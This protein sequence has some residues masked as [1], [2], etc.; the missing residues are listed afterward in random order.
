M[1]LFGGL[2]SVVAGVST[3]GGNIITS[4]IEK[5]TGKKLGRTTKE[6]F[7]ESKTG[8]VL[9]TGGALAITGL[10]GA[11]AKALV[12]SAGG[13]RAVT[14]KIV[15]NPIGA[16]KTT[17]GLATTSG[18]VAGGGL[19]LLPKVFDI[20]KSAT[21]TLTGEKPLTSESSG[22]VGKV[23]GGVLAGTVVGA[24]AGA[25]LPKVVDA[26]KGKDKDSVVSEPSI[27]PEPS[28]ARESLL[29][30]ED[31]GA[32]SPITPQTQ[33]ISTELP[34]EP[35][36]TPSGAINKISNRINIKIRAGNKR[37]IKQNQYN[38]L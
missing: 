17:L 26:V 15:G 25:V 2:K 4:G 6:E 38:R 18:V 24:V 31:T 7:L 23:V 10:A 8:N 36:T 20:S 12:T 28:T 11:G 13:V 14:N 29:E 22:D 37:Y 33:E 27:I 19:L 32:V 16:I 5:A 21:E 35:K 34:A 1:G 9:A 30:P 3:K